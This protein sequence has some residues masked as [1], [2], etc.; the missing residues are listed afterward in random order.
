MIQVLKKENRIYLSETKE[1]M[2]CIK[3]QKHCIS[4][5]EA[6]KTYLAVRVNSNSTQK[7]ITIFE[8]LAYNIRFELTE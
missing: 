4:D 7:K 8:C 1:L 2:W 3:K 5:C 6:S